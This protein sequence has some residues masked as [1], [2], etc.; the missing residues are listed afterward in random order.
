[1]TDQTTAIRGAAGPDASR[2]ALRFAR[3]L[4]DV[5]YKDLRFEIRVEGDR[6][7]LRVAWHGRD[8]EDGALKMHYGRWWYLSGHMTR[9][10]VVQTA[11][12]AVMTWEEHETREAFLYRGAAVMAPHFDIDMLAA[13]MTGDRGGLQS[14][15]SDSG[16]VVNDGNCG[17]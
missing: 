13:L 8:S 10:E 16:K 6:C 9:S 4:D 5:Q 15:R 11:F 1:M 3:I 17:D 12:K 14:R 7:F 2:L